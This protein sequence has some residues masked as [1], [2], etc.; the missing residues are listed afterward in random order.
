MGQN[1][2]QIVKRYSVAFKKQVVKEYE[3]G[4]SASALKRKYGLGC[5]H[6]VVKWV[7]KYGR[8]GVRHKLM[9]VQTPKE[10]EQLKELEARVAELEKLVAQLSL[11]KFMLE[12]SLAVAEEQLGHEVKKKPLTPL[13]T[14]RKSDSKKGKAG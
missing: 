12:S 9:V 4:A 13:S 7:K 8:E 2:Q 3:A 1:T 6:M 14:T 5:T 10:Q 11:D